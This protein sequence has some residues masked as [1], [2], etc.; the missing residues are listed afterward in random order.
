MRT[1]L[2]VF[3]LAVNLSYQLSFVSNTPDPA[4]QPAAQVAA[5]NEAAAALKPAA[6]IPLIFGTTASVPPT[7]TLRPTGTP[8][9]PATTPPP[10]TAGTPQP[11]TT[12]AETVGTRQPLPMFGLQPHPSLESG[13]ALSRTLELG[14]RWV[15]LA[16]RLNW[17]TLQTEPNGPIH[18]EHLAGFE[19]ELKALK[20]AGVVPV[21]TV[22]FSPR[23]ATT[24]VPRPTS[25]G[26]IR[27][28]R[29]DEF[30]S[31]L[32]QVVARYRTPEFNVHYWE[33][34]NEVDVDPTLV[35]VDSGVGCWGDVQDPFYGGRVY[36]QML[37]VVTPAI[38]AEDPTA[39]VW[40]GGL[41]LDNPHT[42]RADR[43]RPELFLKGI[44]EAGAAPYFDVVP[45]HA[46]T[47]FYRQVIDHD[48]HPNSDWH[49][50]GGVVQ[51][52]ARFLRAIMREYGV[53]KPLVINELALGCNPV[54]APC[55][56]PLPVFYEAQASHV[57]RLMVRGLSEGIQSVAWYTLTP[58]WRTTELI[59]D[60]GQPKPAF[61]A[62]RQLITR[63]EGA[64]YIGPV[65]YGSGVEAYAFRRD[66]KQVHVVWTNADIQIPISVTKTSFLSA[67]DRDGNPLN[68]GDAGTTWQFGA[69]FQPIYL[70]LR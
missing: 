14:V 48:Q 10:A 17:I 16:G 20:K 46:Y 26:A 44:L 38:K 43:G 62:Y 58:G 59:D 64:T 28:D 70:Q 18:W 24:N 2:L 3:I 7:A 13:M 67:S 8:V 68:A 60:Q 41:L 53:D 4:I 39:Q 52:K 22:M 15:R 54:N 1:W 34:G 11:P 5:T 23:W 55:S 57:V 27:S 12:T 36:G 29:L 40:V 32:R 30:A 47:F 42:T 19:R 6:Y 65:D 45:Y 21:V 69:S 33:L 51:G 61:Y 49:K 25:C 35:P 63:L 37:K 66:G 56:P 50:L 9:P 31:F